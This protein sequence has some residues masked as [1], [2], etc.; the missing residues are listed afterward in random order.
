MCLK[1]GGLQQTSSAI[2]RKIGKVRPGTQM[3]G[4]RV[5][6]ELTEWKRE[7][8]MIAR[9][10]LTDSSVRND[11]GRTPKISSSWV[12]NTSRFWVV[13]ALVFAPIE[14]STVT[15]RAASLPDPRAFPPTPA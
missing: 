11:A 15:P 7:N 10:Y 3:D 14:P 9:L 13:T 8:G 4:L 5:Y 2:S 6:Q 12:R 1:L